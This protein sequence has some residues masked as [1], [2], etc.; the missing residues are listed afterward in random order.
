MKLPRNLSLLE[1]NKAKGAL[2]IKCLVYDGAE[3]HLSSPNPKKLTPI[4]SDQF[5]S[6]RRDGLQTVRVRIA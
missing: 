2:F 5:N 4:L 3:F 1:N 6:R